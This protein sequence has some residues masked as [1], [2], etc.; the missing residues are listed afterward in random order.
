VD[1]FRFPSVF[2]NGLTSV[3][4]FMS[5]Y[6]PS[7]D[8]LWR[9]GVKFGNHHCAANACTPSRGVMITGLY[10]HPESCSTPLRAARPPG[11]QVLPQKWGLDFAPLCGI[12]TG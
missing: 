12:I 5:T 3:G 8:W 2:P 7:I 9:H 1:Q 4:E 11:R 6:L 10:E